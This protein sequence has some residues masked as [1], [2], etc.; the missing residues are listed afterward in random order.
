MLAVIAISQYAIFK[1]EI[2]HAI[3]QFREERPYMAKVREAVVAEKAD[4]KKSGETFKE[5]EHC[6]EMVVILVG[7]FRMGSPD[8]EAGRS[9][10]E[11]QVRT[12]AIAKPI[13]VGRFEVTWNEWD[14]CVAMR[15]CDGSRAHDQTY[16]KGRRPVINVSWSDAK[17][18][19]AWL[20][21]ITGKEYRLLS[22]AE[23]EYAARG[24]TSADQSHPPYPW[25]NT[26]ICRHANLA[27]QS[28][29]RSGFAG[30]VVNCDDKQARTAEAGRY[31]ANAFGL[32]DMHGNVW[33]WVED[34]WHDSYNGAPNDGSAWT[35]ACTDADRRV[36]R[37]GSWVAVPQ[38]LRSANRNG[39]TTG[40]RINNLGFRVGRTLTP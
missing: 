27:D 4:A 9:S 39:L 40:N 29:R 17:A 37:G 30:D 20:S 15:G 25:G 38:V 24:V 1:A 32:H 26:E 21:R 16:G 22:E 3:W 28:F 35:T 19:V 18:Y 14:A 23:W 11:D 31:P 33:E 6:P 7:S 8:S 10:D 36:V 13:A 12:V 5:C 2:D 34:C